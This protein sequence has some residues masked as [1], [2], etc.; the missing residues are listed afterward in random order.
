M[1]RNMGTL[2]RAARLVLAAILLWIAFG[3]AF[4]AS[5]ALHWLAILVAIVFAGTALIGNCPAYSIVG[6]KTCKTS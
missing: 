6:I 2:D 5:G 4:A 1:T 3:T